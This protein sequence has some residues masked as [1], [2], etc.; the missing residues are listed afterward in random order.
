MN[1]IVVAVSLI[2]GLCVIRP[3]IGADKP[4]V[5]ELWPGAVPDDVGDIGA[6]RDQARPLVD[7][8]IVESAC[9]VVAGIRRAY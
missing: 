9:F 8:P 6:S 1:R 2:T 5:V 4:L 3:V 7:H